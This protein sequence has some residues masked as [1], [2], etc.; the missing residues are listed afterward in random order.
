MKT[1]K[2]FILESIV[3]KIEHQAG[4]GTTQVATTAGTYKKSGERLKQQIPVDGRVLNY[5]AGLEQTTHGL[6]AGLGG[7]TSKHA[8]HD[9]EPF[10]DR[11][12]EKPT[13]TKSEEV[14]KDHYH[15]VVCHN[16]LNVVEP[17]IRDHITRHIFSSMKE[18]GVAHIGTRKF[19]GDIDTAKNTK[20]ADEDKAVWVKKGSQHV[21]QKGFDGDELKNYIEGEA[22]RHGHEVE[23]KKVAGLSANGVEV[24]MKMRNPEE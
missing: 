2:D 8:V 15:A 13:F 4:S 5:G 10:A 17:H 16:V 7:D 6:K 19:K 21:Y 12:K 22:K 23:V 24:H 9:Y 14:P 3:H 1:L 18:G 11:R 20:P